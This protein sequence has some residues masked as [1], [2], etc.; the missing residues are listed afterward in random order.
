MSRG[1][2]LKKQRP[3]EPTRRC[4]GCRQARPAREMLRIGVVAGKAAP[5]PQ[6][7]L[8][9]RGAWMCRSARCAEAVIKGRQLSRA[10]KGKAR[11]PSSAELASWMANPAVLPLTP[12]PA[13]S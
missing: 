3:S 9:G 1:R 11:E 12:A 5:D 13:S 2:R 10:L 7:K 8:P 6:R 4:I